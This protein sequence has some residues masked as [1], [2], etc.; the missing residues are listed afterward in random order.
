MFQS[1]EVAS[2]RSTGPARL[3]ALREA[4][5]TC[6]VDGFLVPRADVHQGEYVTPCDARLQ[7]L[8]GFSGSAGSANWQG[9]DRSEEARSMAWLVPGFVA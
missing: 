1:F 9:I 6:D 7:W 3:T 5:A 2:D 8:T 4:L